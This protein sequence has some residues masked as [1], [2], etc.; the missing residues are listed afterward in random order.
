M[1]KA[2][3][4]RILSVLAAASRILIVSHRK[5]DGDTIGAALAMAQYCELIG[6]PYRC[7]CI[8]KPAEY[9][10]FLPKAHEITNDSAVW[11]EPGLDVVVVVDAGDLKYAGVDQ[12]VTKLPSPYTLI[13]IDHHVTNPGYGHLNLIDSGASSACEIVYHLLNSVRAI[14][15]PTATCL[16]TGLI[17]DTGSFSNL[18]TTANAVNT[19]AELLAKGANLSQISKQ[20]LQYRPYN[21]L[22]LWGRALER[23]HEDPNS[24]MIVTAIT[25]DDV[26]ECHADEEAVSGIS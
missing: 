3:Q 21:T 23:L 10:Q 17:T 18:A 6:K 20:A 22:K 24:G 1:V 15:R 4:Q 12:L 19:A 25:L 11:T 7:F 8:D 9:L 13:N 26:H 14:N 16:M 2:L 5:P